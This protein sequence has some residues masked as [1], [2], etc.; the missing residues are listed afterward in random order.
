MVYN[1]AVKHPKVMYLSPR[2]NQGIACV[3]Y[4][5]IKYIINK[6]KI[7]IKSS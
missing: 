4:K 2:V 3:Y 7:N 6:I 5:N 1:Q